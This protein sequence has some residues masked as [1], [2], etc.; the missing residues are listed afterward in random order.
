VKRA[1]VGFFAVVLL[2]WLVPGAHAE[3]QPTWSR[4]LSFSAHGIDAGPK[5]TV[6][7]VGSTR[8]S[9]PGGR[10]VLRAIH[11][12][13]TV[14]WGSDWRP[15]GGYARASDVDIA[16]ELMTTSA[17]ASPETTPAGCEEIGSFAWMVRGASASG[18]TEWVRAQPSW[19]SECMSR[20]GDAVGV[21]GGVVA[22]ATT[23]HIEGFTDVHGEI[24]GFDARGT[25]LWVN[26]FEPFPVGGPDGYDADRVTAL[27]VDGHGRT[28]AAGWAWRYPRED[29]ADHEAVLMALD[30]AGHRRWVRV[31]GEPGQPR[32]DRDLGTDIEVRG[33][34]VVFGAM[35]D[36]PDG[37]SVA[38]VLAYDTA[39]NLRWSAGF[40]ARE[41]WSNT[42]QVAPGAN[43]TVYVANVRPRTDDNDLIVRKL[44]KGGRVI[45][46]LEKNERVGLV[47]LT[48]GDGGLFVLARRHLWRFPA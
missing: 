30:P 27:A 45:W 21:G 39:G 9:Y 2:L 22:L 1:L 29:G 20:S 38:R 34:R 31:L 46:S 23:Q 44:A 4:W 35:I 36:R 3:P 6:V 47:D 16:G 40:P 26:R 8:E 32:D 18:G 10:I 25:P 15:R 11:A 7:V 24:R 37:P 14:A 19:R 28:Y 17:V 41:T 48:V 42:V 43:G 33:D 12:D 13:G 5:G